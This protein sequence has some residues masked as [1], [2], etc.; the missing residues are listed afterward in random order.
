VKSDENC[1]SL[2]L[3][4]LDSVIQFLMTIA[5][6]CALGSTGFDSHGAGRS[7]GMISRFRFIILICDFKCL[8]LFLSLSG[9]RCEHNQSDLSSSCFHLLRITSFCFYEE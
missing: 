5:I 4:C 6:S 1:F 8:S 7:V 2:R 9:W 3:R